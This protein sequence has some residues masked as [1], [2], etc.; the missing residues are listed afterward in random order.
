M[1]A[2]IIST[3]VLVVVVVS[4]LASTRTATVLN[5][6]TPAGTVQAYLK[7]VL[8]GKNDEAIRLISRESSCTVS[9]LDRAYVVD[10]ARVILTG[11]EVGGDTA[12][13]RVSVEHSANGLFNGSSSEG[14]IFHLKKSGVSWLL[15]GVP[16]P[17]YNCDPVIK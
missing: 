11:T 17:L 12:Q 14:Q 2:I 3:I 6:D 9:D 7:Y 16:W 5:R 10:A 1:L 4:I 13:V 8:A 15:T